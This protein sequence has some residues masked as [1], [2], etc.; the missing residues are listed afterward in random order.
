MPARNQR[1]NP[2]RSC[3]RPLSGDQECIEPAPGHHPKQKPS[4]DE[5]GSVRT[6]DLKMSATAVS[7]P[8]ASG[9]ESRVPAVPMQP[10][11]SLVS[12][13]LCWTRQGVLLWNLSARSL[14][15]SCIA[16]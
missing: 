9:P 2:G 5:E 14:A 12:P 1:Q 11:C 8:A 13:A 16:L 7:R 4:M 6:A 3:L 10:V 15:I